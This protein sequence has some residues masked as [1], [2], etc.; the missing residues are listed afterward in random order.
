MLFV[1]AEGLRQTGAM[2]MVTRPLLGRPKSLPA[3]Q[4]RLMLPVAA[5]RGG[6]EP[7]H[8]TRFYLGQYALERLC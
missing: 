6:S 1:I 2:A 7:R 8:V 3:A 5:L 4:A